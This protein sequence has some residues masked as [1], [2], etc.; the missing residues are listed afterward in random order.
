M[1]YFVI[2]FLGDHERPESPDMNEVEKPQ[3]PVQPRTTPTKP[4]PKPYLPPK[5]A[6][7]NPSLTKTTRNTYLG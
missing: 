6:N 7:A 1:F 3:E 4:Q 5:P 2:L